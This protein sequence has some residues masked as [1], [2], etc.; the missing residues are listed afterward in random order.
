MA[1][2]PSQLTPVPSPDDDQR[3]IT[4]AGRN[5]LLGRPQWDGLTEAEQRRLGELVNKSLQKPG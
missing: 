1:N 2:E 3:I 5:A 4:R